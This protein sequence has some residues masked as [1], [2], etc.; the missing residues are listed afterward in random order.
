[1]MT[2]HGRKGL[3]TMKRITI[4]LA[5]ALL[6]VFGGEKIASA[7]EILLEGPLAGE[8]AVRKLVQYR[9]LRFSAGPQFAYTLLNNYEHNFQIGL[10]LDFNIL[11]WLSV[12][13]VGYYSF[14]APTKL[15]QYVSDSTDISGQATTPAS[16]NFP[17]YGGSANFEDQVALLK[18]VYL[19]QISLVPFRGKMSMFEKLFVAI[20]GYIFLG[21]G[22]VQISEREECP[23]SKQTE[24]NGVIDA[25]GL[26]SDGTGSIKR[27]NRVTGTFTAGIG[28]MAYFNEW[29]ALNLE[30][31][32][33]P[34]KW[35]EGGTDES[36]RAG[37]RWVLEDG[38]DG[39]VWVTKYG[40]AGDYPDGQITK[41]DRTWNANQ[42]IALGFIFYFPLHPRIAN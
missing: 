23:Y 34:F 5:F 14:N 28:F 40:K 16:S 1:M 10:R 6:T 3:D 25:C 15:T 29:F 26:R 8:P 31:R 33:T 13:A 18:G 36:G 39:P 4:A 35:N 38:A 19:G 9:Q 41:D 27:V 7:Q 32:L 21:G 42:S 30:Y 2:S 12:G 17:S 24:D 11:E 20:D 37:K 22:A